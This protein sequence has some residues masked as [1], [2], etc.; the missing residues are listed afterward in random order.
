[1]IVESSDKLF[2]LGSGVVVREYNLA[3]TKLVEEQLEIKE[4]VYCI[5]Y[6][7]SPKNIHPEG[8]PFSRFSK[9]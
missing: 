7:S 2:S 9:Q 3:L 5:E 8:F 4:L 1:M 6:G